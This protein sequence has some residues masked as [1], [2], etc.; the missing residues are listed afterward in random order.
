MKRR[1]TRED[2]WVVV[3]DAD[4]IS[5][6]YSECPSLRKALALGYPKTLTRARHFRIKSH[7]SLVLVSQFGRGNPVSQLFKSSEPEEK[8][9]VV[10]IFTI[11]GLVTTTHPTEVVSIHSGS[12]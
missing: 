5:Q 12:E 7:I 9:L 1:N 11:S 10:A 3:L 4:Y 2:C 6:R 8:C